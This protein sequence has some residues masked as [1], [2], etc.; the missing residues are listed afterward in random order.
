VTLGYIMGLIYSRLKFLLEAKRSGVEYTTT[1]MIGNQKIS[2]SIKEKRAIEKEY[3]ISLGTMSFR[4]NERQY[5]D[6]LIRGALDI[7]NLGI[8]DYSDYEGANLL[9]DLNYEIPS[10]MYNK[11]DAVIDGGT[12]EHVFNFPAAIKNYMNMIKVNGSIFIFSNANNHCGH[13]FYQFSPELFYSIFSKRNGFRTES[14]VLMEH[15]YPGALAGE[16]Q[17]CYSVKNPIDVRRRA[18]I[19]NKSP[20]GI[21]VHA[22]KE[23]EAKIFE[24]FPFQ[25][26]YINLWEKKGEDDTI[27]SR[28]N[29]YLR[30]AI[31]HFPNRLKYKIMSVKQL[32]NSSLRN[33]KEFFKQLK[34]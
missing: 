34:N 18:I 28:I 6:M 32:H 5:A 4:Y 29:N 19:V 20:L 10:I 23:K 16:K 24:T 22:K 33:D 15:K 13:G 21:M 26:D 1:A 31:E 9:I 11:Y 14:V 3:G 30:T 12:I 8:I 17:V 25:S 7:K 2:L 27:R